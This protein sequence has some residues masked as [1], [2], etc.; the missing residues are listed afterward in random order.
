MEVVQPK[1]DDVAIEFLICSIFWLSTHD[2]GNH[3]SKARPH[4]QIDKILDNLWDW[5]TS[6]GTCSSLCLALIYCRKERCKILPRVSY[7]V[8]INKFK[9]DGPLTNSGQITTSCKKRSGCGKYIIGQLFSIYWIV[10]VR[11]LD[12]SSVLTESVIGLAT[13][14]QLHSAKSEQNSSQTTNRYGK[15]W[16]NPQQTTEYS[17][18]DN[19]S[20]EVYSDNID[21]P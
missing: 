14:V 4:K 7:F 10:C 12:M 13:Q 15:I 3:S 17:K 16:Y 11:C 9:T 21:I 1:G 19:H 6:V 8:F 2:Y 18:S 5:T 20:P